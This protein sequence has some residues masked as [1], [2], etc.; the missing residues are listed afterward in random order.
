MSDN[1]ELKAGHRGRLRERF[2]K[3]GLE[4]FHDY[5][6]VELLLTYAIPRRDV[7]P[8]AK[9]LIQRFKGLRGVF[10]ATL[11]EL[12]TVKGVGENAA[13]LIKLLKEAAGAYL[14]EGVM[15]K[16]VVRSAKDVVDYLNLTLSGEKVEKFLALYLNSKNEI[17]GVETLHEGSIDRTF[18]YPRKAIENAF[19]HNA[20]SVIFVHNHPSGD[21]TPSEVDRKLTKELEAAASALDIIV[22]DHI[23]IGEKTHFSGKERGWLGRGRRA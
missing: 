8:L 22:H 5:E 14:K 4:G 3:S 16:D 23:I 19:K 10:D 6:A 20:R 7:K 13:V 15:K 17:L 1:V 2:I 9:I 21:P 11:E 12:S 18:V